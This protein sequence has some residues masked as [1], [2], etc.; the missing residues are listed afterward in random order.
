MLRASAYEIFSW[1]WTVSFSRLLCLTTTRW[2]VAGGDV[3]I[4]KTKNNTTKS[5]R[6]TKK[7]R[8][9]QQRQEARHARKIFISLS[10]EHHRWWDFFSATARNFV[11]HIYMLL[12]KNINLPCQPIH[13]TSAVLSRQLLNK[14][15]A[16]LSGRL[17]TG[18]AQK[19]LKLIFHQGIILIIVIESAAWL[20][21]PSRMKQARE[22]SI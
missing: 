13:L 10:C 4:A 14:L 6:H 21:C 9:K 7:G 11:V 18:D 22:R 17:L 8:K 19:S 15:R 2:P 16:A 20:L 1:I 12:Y 3:Q 5:L